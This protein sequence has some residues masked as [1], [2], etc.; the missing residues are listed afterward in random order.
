MLCLSLYQAVIATPE[1]VV[2]RRQPGSDVALVLACD[3]VWDIR[4]NDQV[5]AL[6]ADSIGTHVEAKAAYQEAV[7]QACDELLT[8]SVISRDNVSTVIV[9]LEERE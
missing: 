9:G 6:V 3:G 2:Y 8:A 1:I 7:Y 5:A 4:E